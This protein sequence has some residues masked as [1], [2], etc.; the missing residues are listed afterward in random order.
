MKNGLICSLLFA[1]LLYSAAAL[2]QRMDTIWVN[3]AYTGSV[4][5]GTVLQPFKTI[6]GALNK[7]ASFR[8]YPMGQHEYIIVKEGYY[9]PSGTDLIRIDS[10]NCGRNGKWLTIKSEVPF[11]A[12]IRGDSL[13]RTLYSAIVGFTDSASYVRLEN[14]TLEHLRNNPDS[15]K[16]RSATD[17]D[18]FYT[19][20]VPVLPALDNDNRLARTL[21]GDTVYQGRR[22][23]KFGIQIS[24]DCRHITIFD[25]DISDISWTSQVDPYKPDSALT[26]A[27]K[28]ILRNA[29]GADVVGPISVLGTDY[30]AMQNIIL[31]GNE[32]HHCIP[33][34]AEG[35]AV[36]GYIDSFQIINNL[37]HDIKNIG[38]VAA[39]NYPW[40][41][42]PANNFF[43]PAN[44]N[45]SRNGIISDNIVYNC[46]SPIAASAGIYL[47]GSRNVLVER[48]VVYNNHVGFSVGNEIQNSHSGGHTIRNNI[49]YD[50][51]WTGLVLGS[52]S[53]GTWIENTKVL[54]NTFY[55]NNTQVVTLIPATIDHIAVVEN[56]VAL[57]YAFGNAGEVIVKRLSN[58]AD[59]PNAK[60]VVQNNI[61]RSRKG[62]PITVSDSFR[63]NGYT[64]QP[65]IKSN[66]KTLLDWNYN[67]YYTEPGQNINYDF[68]AAGFIGNTYNFANY[69]TE[70][71]LDSASAAVELFTQ[72]ATDPVFAGGAAFPGRF[73]LVS[74]SPAINMGN[75][76]SPN[77]GTDDFVYSERILGG[78]ID[79]GALE[80]VT[81]C[82]PSARVSPEILEEKTTAALYPNPAV[83]EVALRFTKNAPGNATVEMNDVGGRL[84][85]RKTVA[86]QEGVNTL[87][88]ANLKAAGFK[89]GIYFVNL[90][91]NNTRL[92]F[93]LLIQ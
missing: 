68:A 50:N 80:F 67:L 38:I 65:L 12:T 14:F 8:Q 17:P 63:V 43:T 18:G 83:D 55:K 13:Y 23:V 81:S 19:S 41:L 42:N 26:E 45:F 57:P 60:I 3:A 34:Y 78:R 48:N 59:A 21:Y 47:D 28:K 75:P 86:A 66:L 31:D 73:G 74:G 35:I 25:N 71:G 44:Q 52:G 36:N 29:S 64:S 58:S 51:V 76:S 30:H 53:A 72:P 27:E 84:L 46:Q 56:G 88:I 49:S 6:R 20:P 70:T 85:L 32:V 69:K 92:T 15:T 1:A 62:V 91:T 16:W 24:S 33:G 5:T 87:R 2:A 40:V 77:S 7:R 82:G 90:K 54:N 79:A 39:G 9:Y 89:K 10:T 61:L 4:Q 37:V 22:D 93:K 11:A